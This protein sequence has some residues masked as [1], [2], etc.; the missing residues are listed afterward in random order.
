[1]S[2]DRDRMTQ[3][4]LDG[5]FLALNDKDL[6]RIDRTFTEDC[7]MHIPSST[8]FYRNKHDLMV[9]L[10]DFVESFAT[11]DFHD[12]IVIPDPQTGRVAATFTVTLVEDNGD[13]TE[14]RNANFFEFAE[15]HRICRIL[16]IATQPL[17]KGF[18]A[19]RS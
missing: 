3:R 10:Q 17:D 1:M 5:F 12:F 9:H 6:E 13:T 8:L 2:F 18:Q 19:G 14:M 16:I 4:C 15:D 7:E 11:I